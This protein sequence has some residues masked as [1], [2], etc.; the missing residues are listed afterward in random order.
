MFGDIEFSVIPFSTFDDETPE[1]YGQL[2]VNICPQQS[3]WTEQGVMD[4]PTKDC[5][6]K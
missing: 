1:A 6:D 4:I 5:G 2:W 3:L